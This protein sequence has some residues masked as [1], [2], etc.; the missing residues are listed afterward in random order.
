MDLRDAGAIATI[1]IQASLLA[2]KEIFSSPSSMLT[3]ESRTP[4]WRAIISSA[5]GQHRVLVAE[6]SMEI[7]GYAH[8]GPSRDSDQNA[9]TIGELYSIYVAPERWR[10][11]VGGKLLFKSID[12]L[13][14][15]GF[16]A[17]T[18][19][20]LAANYPARRFYERYGWRFEGTEKPAHQKVME[21][22]YRTDGLAAQA[23]SK[24]GSAT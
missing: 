15:A 16:V 23:A 18:L 7:C 13:A 8:F 2:Y 11:G 17:C 4:V 6:H 1:Q 10:Q 5:Q 20:V 24:K 9:M 22:R 21:V 12:T 3:V 14:R 19:W